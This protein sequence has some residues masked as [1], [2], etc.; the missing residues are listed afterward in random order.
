MGQWSSSVD[1]WLA[2]LVL[3]R[4]V[5]RLAALEARWRSWVRF[6][7]GVA[8]YGRRVVLS[9]GGGG[10]SR[11]AMCGGASFGC[12]PVGVRMGVAAP[13]CGMVCVRKR[14]RL[15]GLGGVGWGGEHPG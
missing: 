13:V 14:G 12:G 4:L 15:V 3:L 8:L 5:A 6:C 2:L 10:T 9:V 11:W 1:C 7:T